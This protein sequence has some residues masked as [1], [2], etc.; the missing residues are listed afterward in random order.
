MTNIATNTLI[1]WLIY[2]GGLP[3]VALSLAL[4]TGEYTAEMEARLQSALGGYSF[5]IAAFMAGTHWGQHWHMR[6]EVSFYLLVLSNVLA[7]AL[8]VGL[9]LLAFKAALVLCSAVFIVLLGIDY[10]LLRLR[11]LEARYFAHRLRITV[12]VLASLMVA[13]AA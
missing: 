7:I 9:V 5:V 13:L 10:T 6:E 12:V 8:W 4:L 3:F 2:L 11:Q 1:P